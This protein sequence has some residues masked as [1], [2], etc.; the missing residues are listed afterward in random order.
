MPMIVVVED[1]D[2][3]RTFISTVLRK[4][5]VAVKEAVD[6]GAGLEMIRQEMP[7]LV[8]SDVQMPSMDGFQMLAHMRAESRLASIPVI[9]LTSLQQRAHMRIGMTAGADD[10]L[11]KPFRPAELIDAVQA[12][13]DKLKR[14]EAWQSMAIEEAV[15]TAL[16]EQ[17]KRIS[18]LY[19]NR[20][21]RTV[22]ERWPG[23]QAPG[24]ERY[25][26]ATVLFVDICNYSTWAER[27][28]GP[29]LADLVQQFYSSAGDTVH[30]F[31]AKPMQFVG[32]GMISV[33]AAE[34]D[35]H[36]VNHGLR[37]VKAAF[38][39]IEARKRVRQY[40]QTYFS[41]RQLPEFNVALALHCGPVTL[42]HLQ[43]MLGGEGQPTPVGDTVAS[44][45][46]LQRG[47]LQHGW[48]VAATVQVMRLVTGAVRAGRRVLVPVEG[49]SLPLD[50]VE[51]LGIMAP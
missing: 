31:G 35:T 34:H 39:L 11:T 36:S 14:Q 45:L 30:L 50:A 44:A 24:V 3:T 13:F 42:A 22:S 28:S 9:L 27:L 17:Q 7:D 20:L 6:G 37:A 5:G 51:L 41:D 48:Q 10:Y 47:A 32:E 25:A 49:R 33:F 43:G 12:Q 26:S 38:G 18:K 15:E 29:E 21:A 16:T 46:A 4:L 19:E 23:D 2:G 8:V 40:V 1:D